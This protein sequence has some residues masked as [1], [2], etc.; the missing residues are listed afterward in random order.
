MSTNVWSPVCAYDWICV[1]LKDNKI[2]GGILILLIGFL[3]GLL[4]T[5]TTNNHSISKNWRYHFKKLSR[6]YIVT[7]II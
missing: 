5:A 7:L 6:L 1:H 3:L 4:F 2:T